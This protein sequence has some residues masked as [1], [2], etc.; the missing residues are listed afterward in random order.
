MTL[1]IWSSKREELRGNVI[2]YRTSV[3]MTQTDVQI[4]PSRTWSLST[5]A[6]GTHEDA[7]PSLLGLSLRLCSP[8]GAL[9]QVWHILDILEGSPAQSAGPSFC[10]SP[11]LEASC[12]GQVWS[13]M[14]IM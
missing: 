1:S 7:Q 8:E 3:L 12:F 4:L 10:S 14:A 6:V 9:D 13:A 2:G 11:A 5:K